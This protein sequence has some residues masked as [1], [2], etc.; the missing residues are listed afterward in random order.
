MLLI[1]MICLALLLST[2]I[3]NKKEAYLI[4]IVIWTATSYFINEILSIN[5][6]L[7][8]KHLLIIY[9]SL[10][11]VVAGA[12]IYQI[13]NK[14]F[15]FNLNVSSIWQKS[16]KE[17]TV[18]V[19]LGVFLLIMFVASLI[20]IPHTVDSMTYN[21]TRI[22]YWTQNKSVAHYATN[23]VR[24]VTT[25][26]LAEFINLQV[27]I[28]HNK[29]D[30]LF[31]LLQSLS[32]ITNTFLVMGICKKIDLSKRY[33]YLCALLYISMPIAFAEALTTQ[34]EQFAT[35]W[36]LIFVYF[37]LDIIDKDFR[38]SLSIGTIGKVLILGACIAFGYL[39]KPSVM[40]GMLVFAFWLLFACI[41]RKERL[42]TLL[43]L[44]AIATVE[45]LV[46]VMPEIARNLETFHAVSSSDVGA[47]HMIDTLNPIY[48]IINALKNASI[49]LPNIYFPWIAKF[50]SHCIFW[51][52]YKCNVDINDPVIAHDGAE[53]FLRE[54]QWYVCDS[55]VNPVVF[56]LT[57]ITLAL[58]LLNLF[59]RKGNDKKSTFAWA[60]IISFAFFCFALKYEYYGVRYM[61]SYLALLCPVACVGISKIEYKKKSWIVP[62]VIFMCIVELAGLF[63]YHGERVIRHFGA[64]DR[65]VGYFEF[66]GKD[67]NAYRELGE[68]LST[69]EFDSLGIYF[70]WRSG[71]YPIWKMV[72]ENVRIGAVNVMNETVIHQDEDF[73]PD[74][75]VVKDADPKDIEVYKGNS[76][77]LE[78]ETEDKIYLYRKS[79]Q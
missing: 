51:I 29:S 40:F 73:I 59:S 75:I 1:Y 47:K 34:I 70:T 48:L 66:R 76:Y 50:V 2:I 64:E 27:Y 20:M 15:V 14:R 36:L 45:M 13:V 49:N 21:M 74:Y 43:V 31:N 57:V 58:L 8:K 52:A 44:I 33:R 46:L 65:I 77:Q 71:E 9:I 23:D 60:G 30:V 17:K 53:Y 38:F 16:V 5:N 68:Y 42:S 4:A 79:E 56:Y 12:L 55:A 32:Y 19:L 11:I 26:P 39:S 37:I 67:E 78:W 22:A 61:L 54:P 24:A 18:V 35:M 28:L 7:D 6:L 72:N 63:I 10:C 25:S 41:K 62:I 69:K 3:N